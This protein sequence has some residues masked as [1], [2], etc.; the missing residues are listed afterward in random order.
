[1]CGLLFK[2]LA[3]VHSSHKLP[4]TIAEPRPSGQGAGAGGRAGVAEPAGRGGAS[5]IVAL[6][7]RRRP[8]PRAQQVRALAA[9]ADA[10]KRLC[11]QRR[12]RHWLCACKRVVAQRCFLH[13]L[14][15]CKRV[16]LGGLPPSFSAAVK[17]TSPALPFAQSGGP[18]P[19]PQVLATCRRLQVLHPAEAVHSPR[20]HNLCVYSCH[21]L[22]P[23]V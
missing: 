18:S 16:V 6:V 14:P 5:R 15:A 21:S 8:A 1:M 13:W 3:D 11:A 20:F 4:V 10:S 17:R 9:R 2:V 7:A 12:F 22:R 19:H 23:R